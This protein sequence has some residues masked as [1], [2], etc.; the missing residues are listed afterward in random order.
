MISRHAIAFALVVLA[1]ADPAAAD[2]TFRCGKWIVNS[3]L[4]PAELADKC[5]PP[6][7]HESS[8]EDV[9]VRNQNTGLMM[10]TGESR[11]EIWTYDRGTRAA[12]M[13]V[14][15]IDGRIKSIDRKK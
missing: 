10:K 4:T 3:S 13:V 14:T 2:E 8:T 12:P 1:A 7:W 15:I 9:L 11:I 6:T 5:G